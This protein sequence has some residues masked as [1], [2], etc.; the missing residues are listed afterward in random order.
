MTNFERIKNMTVE[1]MAEKNVTN[2]YNPDEPY[3][4]VS[5]GTIFGLDDCEIGKMSEEEIYRIALKYELKWLQLESE[6]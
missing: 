3:Y 5:D 1:E 6:E 2:L 4:S